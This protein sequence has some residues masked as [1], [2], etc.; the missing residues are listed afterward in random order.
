MAWWESIHNDSK[1]EFN[2]S[3]LHERSARAL[4][5]TLKRRSKTCERLPN[6]RRMDEKV[7]KKESKKLRKKEVYT[8]AK[9]F[10][11]C[12]EIRSTTDLKAF[13]K[14]CRLTPAVLKR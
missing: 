9:H 2:E 10:Y 6:S 13:N 4:E 14:A 5:K 3:V 12:K 1:H 11:N 7:G 8:N